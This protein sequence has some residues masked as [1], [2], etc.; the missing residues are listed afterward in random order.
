MAN[1]KPLTN[2]DGEV[3]ELTNEDFAQAVPFSALP[4]ELQQVLLSEKKI[5]PEVETETTRQ[6]AA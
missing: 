5:V 4:A 6:P 3:R 1:P 2:D